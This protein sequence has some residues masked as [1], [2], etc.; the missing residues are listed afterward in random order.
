MNGSRRGPGPFELHLREALE[1]NRKR[2]PLYAAL[3]GGESQ[4]ISRSLI[5][6]EWMLIPVAR[7][8]DRRARPY[9]EGGVPLLEDV[10]VSMSETPDF[11]EFREPQPRQPAIRL[12]GPAIGRG[13]RRAFVELGFAGA[14]ARLEEELRCLEEEPSFHCMT[15]HLLESTLRISLL[16]PLHARAA[17]ARGLP[18]PIAL[19]RQLIR[20]HLWGIPSA[21]RLDR[22]AAPIQQRGVPILCQDVPPIPPLPPSS[23]EPSR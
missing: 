21:V 12:D 5:R 10:F 19:F 4:P 17:T 6:M 1:L 15:R 14:A 2:A 11:A 9:H 13:V 20:I 7:W 22:R 23:S 16:A 3:T 8:Y 18:S